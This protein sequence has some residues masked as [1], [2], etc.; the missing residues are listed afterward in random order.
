MVECSV[1]GVLASEDEKD[2]SIDGVLL[3]ESDTGDDDCEDASEENV[4]SSEN[5]RTSIINC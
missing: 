4:V 2:D 1:G 5:G 3:L